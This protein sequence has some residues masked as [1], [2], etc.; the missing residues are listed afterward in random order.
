MY[1]RDSSEHHGAGS[2]QPT[3]R[4]AVLL[5]IAHLRLLTERDA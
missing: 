3:G 4:P 1:D 2:I 5:E